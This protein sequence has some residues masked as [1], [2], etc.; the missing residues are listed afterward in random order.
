MSIVG[1][2]VDLVSLARIDHVMAQH[3]AFLDRICTEKEQ[4][5][6]RRGGRL[7]VASIAGHFAAKEA[8]SKALGTGI[9]KVRW[10]DLEIDHD[11][12]GAP[13][14]I[15]HGAAKQRAETLGCHRTH[16]SISHEKDHAIAMVIL[17]E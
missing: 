5:H 3:G 13:R 16:I 10:H 7:H 12:A 15:F 6:C 17:E 2:G 8:A 4:R 9:G 11:A 1:I 14:L